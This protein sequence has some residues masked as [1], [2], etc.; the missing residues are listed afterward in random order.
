M[1][2]SRWS[3]T[4]VGSGSSFVGNP[5]GPVIPLT[6]ESISSG[7]WRYTGR[8]G[9]QAAEG[10]PGQARARARARARRKVY[11]ICDEHEYEYEYER[12]HDSEGVA[13][14]DRHPRIGRG[15]ALVDR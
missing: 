10:I 6:R 9:M 11:V 14:R 3:S 5:P 1:A 13:E 4:S 2:R 8:S 7:G 15:D 12:E